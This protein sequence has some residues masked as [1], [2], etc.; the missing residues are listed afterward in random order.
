MS[1]RKTGPNG[2][3][4]TLTPK[5]VKQIIGYIRL[6]SYI[7][8]ACQ[9]CGVPNSTLR[10]WLTQAAELRK[11]VEKAKEE[12][13]EVTLSIDETKLLRFLKAMDK[14]VA[15]AEM[16]DLSTIQQASKNAWQ[17]AA[18]R[19]E[20]RFPDRWGRRDFVKSELSGPEGG[21]I[22][23]E[24][25]VMPMDPENVK[26]AYKEKIRREVRAEMEAG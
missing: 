25:T 21:P 23:T 2:R 5:L 20:R 7:E 1:V 26:K 4:L 18:W 9:A 19:L 8:T 17:A 11:I 6:G 14:A 22:Q 10:V 15:E 3:P 16:L 13:Q 12:G 24:Q